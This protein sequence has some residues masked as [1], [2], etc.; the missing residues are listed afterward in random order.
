MTKFIQDVCSVSIRLQPDAKTSIQVPVHLLHVIL[1]YTN[2]IVMC[3]MY[4]FFPIDVYW[5]KITLHVLLC[6]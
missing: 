1:C 3:S 6:N 2:V 4:T 5:G